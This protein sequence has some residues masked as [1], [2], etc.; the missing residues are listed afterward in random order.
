[1]TA[2]TLLVAVLAL[3]PVAVASSADAAKPM[4]GDVAVVGPFSASGTRG[5][6][7]QLVAGRKPGVGQYTQR[8]MGLGMGH[9][10]AAVQTLYVNLPVGG[11]VAMRRPATYSSNGETSSTIAFEGF[12]DD[13]DVTLLGST[14]VHDI[15]AGD[16]TTLPDRIANDRF[17]IK[18]GGQ[19]VHTGLSGLVA[20]HTFKIPHGTPTLEYVRVERSG[21]E[22]GQDGY[23]ARLVNLE[24][25]TAK[26]SQ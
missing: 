25:P 4:S 3:F 17:R 16:T 23:K 9:G 12:D 21:A 8:V 6:R 5:P 19:T 1:M 13:A 2:K 18:L 20:E 22:H 10:G 24:W 11:R 15:T 14:S 7:A 26:A